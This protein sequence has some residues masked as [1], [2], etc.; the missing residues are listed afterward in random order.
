MILPFGTKFID[1]FIKTT[2]KNRNILD[3]IEMLV[4]I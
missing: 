2:Y 4:N 3:W 1:S